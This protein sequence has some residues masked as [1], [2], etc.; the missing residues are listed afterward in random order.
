MIYCST[1]GKGI[2]DDSRFCTFCGSTVPVVDP[3]KP[4][5]AKPSPAS[6]PLSRSTN[7]ESRSYLTEVD[8]SPRRKQF[9]ENPGFYGALLLGIGFFLPWINA[10]GIGVTAYQLLQ[11]YVEEENYF[12]VVIFLLIPIGAVIILVQS[13]TNALPR[14]ISGL[15]KWLA[16][17][18]LLMIVAF[19]IIGINE[20][21]PENNWTGINTSDPDLGLVL[22][23]IGIGL[24]L[25][26]LGSLVMLFNRS[27]KKV[28]VV[29]EY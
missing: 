6:T 20:L 8:N 18:S 10:K 24:W 22:G 1:C 17:I 28:E 5:V 26:L 15:F 19:F 2:P 12:L 7:V 27:Y 21:D 14:V 29:R 25:S 13:L 23:F 4:N 11:S 16:F 3:G 9:Y